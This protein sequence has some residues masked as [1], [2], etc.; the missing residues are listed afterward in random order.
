MERAVRR[1]G[2]AEEKFQA[3]DLFLHQADGRAVTG[4]KP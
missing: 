4:G 3:C 1:V 2:R